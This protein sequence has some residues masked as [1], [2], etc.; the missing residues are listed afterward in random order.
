MCYRDR[1]TERMDKEKRDRTYR[2]DG[3]KRSVGVVTRSD[4]TPDIV[5]HASTTKL[6]DASLDALAWYLADVG[7]RAGGKSMLRKVAAQK[8]AEI[9]AVQHDR[10]VAGRK[11]A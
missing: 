8:V 5:R 6:S 7:L 10:F 4:G 11:A 1:F 2:H 3:S 9:R